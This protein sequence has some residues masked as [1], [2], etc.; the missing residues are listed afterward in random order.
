MVHFCY[1]RLNLGTETVSC[2]HS[3]GVFCVWVWALSNEFSR[4][5][6]QNSNI[7]VS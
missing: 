7:V 3:T 5:F 2:R 4:D 6:T 1:L